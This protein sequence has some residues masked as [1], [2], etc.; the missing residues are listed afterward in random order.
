[1][2][3]TTTTT[4]DG[5]VQRPLY[6]PP[7][8]FNNNNSI[9]QQYCTTQCDNNNTITT[10]QTT[11]KRSSNNDNNNDDKNN[12]NNANDDIINDDDEPYEY[13]SY[14]SPKT[15]V[16]ETVYH[17]FR[18]CIYGAAYGLV[19]PFYTPGSKGYQLEVQTGIFRP[20][21]PFASTNTVATLF[22]TTVPSYAVLMGSLLA[23]QRASCK[24]LEYVRGKSDPWND[25]FG[26][27]MVVPYYQICLTKHALWH[28]R[29][30]GGIILTSLAIANCW[31]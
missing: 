23:C 8:P 26:Y 6:Y 16:T 1:M 18:G 2:T 22:T 15:I 12:T 31:P 10:H 28:N 14:I 5:T 7:F 13:V 9:Y 17:F 29:I 11:C 4:A 21:P 30:V 20:A 25:T 19:T 24:T 3:T 27:F